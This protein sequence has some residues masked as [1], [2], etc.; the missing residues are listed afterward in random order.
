MAKQSVT[1]L[2]KDDWQ[3]VN[4]EAFVGDIRAT[5]VKLQEAQQVAKKAREAFETAARAKLAPMTPPGLTPAFAY[6]FGKLRIAAVEAK[7]KSGKSATSGI[8]L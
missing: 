5:Y 7:P 1:M 2:V 6:R 3:D 4:T 8:T